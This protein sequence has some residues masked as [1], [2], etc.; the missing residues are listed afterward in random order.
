MY[1]IYL[2]MRHTP[3][4]M[5]YSG[6][7]EKCLGGK[8]HNGFDR[9]RSGDFPDDLKKRIQSCRNFIVL[10]TSETFGQ[11]DDNTSWMAYEIETVL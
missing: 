7:L 6:W 10:L 11:A 2:S 1:D 3:L 5:Y 4:S 9:I 8:M